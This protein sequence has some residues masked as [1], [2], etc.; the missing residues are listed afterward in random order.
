MFA[1][2]GR[3]GVEA[4]AEHMIATIVAAV[5]AFNLPLVLPFTHRFGARTLRR[6]IVLSLLA[7]A[8][9][10]AVFAMREPFDEMHQKRLYVLHQED[11][12]A[13]RSS[14]LMAALTTWVL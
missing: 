6:A 10:M 3:I 1:Q 9:T 7:T 8:A 11:V 12:R 14:L 4:P 2:T 5:G 13:S